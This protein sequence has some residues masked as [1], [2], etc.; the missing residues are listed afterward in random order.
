[1]VFTVTHFLSL[2]M[3]WG[4]WHVCEIRSILLEPSYLIL[5]SFSCAASL[6]FSLS[7]NI[8]VKML[9]CGTLWWWLQLKTVAVTR[10]FQLW[11]VIYVVLIWS[12]VYTGIEQPT[13]SSSPTASTQPHSSRCF[14]TWNRWTVS[15]WRWSKRQPGRS[16]LDVTCR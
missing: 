1:M 4:G 12:G 9:V 3:A 11:C 5:S 10:C 14:Q 16:A 8:F 7:Y 2:E 6:E 15:T 13:Q